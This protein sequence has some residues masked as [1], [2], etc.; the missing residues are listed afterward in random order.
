MTKPIAYLLEPPKFD[1]SSLYQDYDVRMIFDD[2]RIPR[3]AMA[4]PEELYAYFVEWAVHSFVAS[5]DYFVLTGNLTLISL[6]SIAIKE[7]HL[8]RINLLRYDARNQKYVRMST[9]GPTQGNRTGVISTGID[10]APGCV[11]SPDT[12]QG[13]S[14]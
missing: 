11:P 8:G 10:N 13:C 2:S 4:H 14:R 12:S 7:A 9:H 6:C 5:E 3:D 1:V